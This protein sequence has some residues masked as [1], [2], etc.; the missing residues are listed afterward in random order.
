MKDLGKVDMILRIKVRRNNGGIVLSQ[1][2]YIEKILN[3]FKHLK[4]KEWKTPYN[5]Q[6]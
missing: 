4:F 6:V 2:H 1:S 5:P 3:K